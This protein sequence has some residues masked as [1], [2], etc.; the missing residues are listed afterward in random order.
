M[1]EFCYSFLECCSLENLLLLNEVLLSQ[2][3]EVIFHNREKINPMN[4]IIFHDTRI[5]A[6]SWEG[7]EKT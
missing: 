2:T 1:Y 3:S 6:T 5:G 7:R 4:I